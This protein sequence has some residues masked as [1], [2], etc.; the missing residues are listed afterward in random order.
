[1]MGESEAFGIWARGF[2][3]GVRF[4]LWGVRRVDLI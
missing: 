3:G 2:L 4:L 1:M